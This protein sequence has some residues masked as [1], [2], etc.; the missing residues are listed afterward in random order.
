MPT[1]NVNN[2]AAI[3]LKANLER[4]NKSAFPSAVRNTLNS[5]TFDMKRKTVL[6]SARKNFNAVKEPKLLRNSLLVDKAT[7]FDVNKMESTIGLVKLNGN[8][9]AYVSGLEKQEKGGVIDTGSRYLKGA[10]G[11]N[12]ANGRVRRENYYDKN[13]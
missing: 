8:L 2:D 3:S 9:E 12:K 13:N 10:R 11:G 4:L 1:F 7:G 6:Q 5:A